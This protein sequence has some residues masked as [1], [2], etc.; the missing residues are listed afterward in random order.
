MTES[1]ARRAPEPA[2]NVI[3]RDLSSPASNGN[4]NGNGAAPPVEAPPVA[5]SGPRVAL[6]AFEGPLDLLLYLIR[7]EQVDISDIPIA[8]ITEQYLATLGDLEELDLDKAGEYLVMAAELMRIKAKMLLPRETD[9]EEEDL[10]DPRAELARRLLEYGEFKRVA[11]AL[12]EREDEWRGIFRRVAGDGEPVDG[13]VPLDVSLVD[14]L[15]AFKAILDAQTKDLPLELEAPP[16]SV[17][18]QIETI[19]REIAGSEDGVAFHRLFE[20]RRSRSLL[21][22]TF[23]ALLELIR[24]REIVARQAER[25]GEI[26]LRRQTEG[27]QVDAS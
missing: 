3:A 16:F 21:I 19:R 7:E 14:L 10:V 26:W 1:D 20:G 9:E 8:R 17:E 2:A 4:G 11:E 24:Q 5:G 6:D 23:L 15:S 18:D 25:F 13:E 27:V 12:A 22:A